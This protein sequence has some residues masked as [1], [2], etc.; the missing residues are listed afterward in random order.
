[1]ERLYGVVPAGAALVDAMLVENNGSLG[2]T[3]DDGARQQQSMLTL[4]KPI[5]QRDLLPTT[6]EPWCRSDVEFS[7][8]QSRW[9]VGTEKIKFEHES[10]AS[11]GKR[12]NCDSDTV[13]GIC[14]CTQPLSS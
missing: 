9:T 13:T 1:M 8:M 12:L 7:A 6:T 2:T 11:V 4:Q 5:C 3:R 14:H 10:E